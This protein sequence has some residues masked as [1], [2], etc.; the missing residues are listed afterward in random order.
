MEFSINKCGV[1]IMNKGKV[2]STD[3][4]ELP[5]DEKI[6]QKKMDTLEY[7]DSGVWQGKRTRNER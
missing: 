2:K 6:G 7:G 4:T 1:I 3:G 5:S